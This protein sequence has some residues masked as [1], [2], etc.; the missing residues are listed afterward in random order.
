MRSA[1]HTRL[2]PP[3]RLVP[4]CSRL[5]TRLFTIDGSVSESRENGSF[6]NVNVMVSFC[7]GAYEPL[8]NPCFSMVFE[9]RRNA[10]VSAALTS[11]CVFWYR[12]LPKPHTWS[13][14]AGPPIVNAVSFVLNWL[15]G[16]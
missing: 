2:Y 6:R 12:K 7:V 11:R 8:A 10:R 1:F 4:P 3:E 14:S 15:A 9:L 16:L 5:R 13:F